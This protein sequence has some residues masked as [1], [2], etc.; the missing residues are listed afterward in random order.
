MT[1]LEKSTLGASA[2][3]PRSSEAAELELTVDCAANF[4]LFAPAAMNRVIIIIHPFP[5]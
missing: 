5:Y 3:H 4:P 1:D 2:N